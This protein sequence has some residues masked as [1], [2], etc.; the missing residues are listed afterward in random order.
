MMFKSKRFWFLMGLVTILALV[1]AACAS[2]ATPAPTEAPQPEPTEAP[3]AAETEAPVTEPTAACT[4][5]LW[6]ALPGGAL[7]KAYNGELEGKVVTMMGPFT[8]GDIVRFEQSIKAFEEKTGIDIQYEG[9][10]E[11]EATIGVRVG[12]NDVPDIVD[13]PQPGLLANF[14]RQGKFIDPTTFLPEEYL[15]EQYTQGWLD[16]GTMAGAD[17]QPATGGIWAR[18]NGKSQVWYP[19]DDFEAAGYAI[20]T[21]WDELIALS[22]QIKADG[23]T[24]W[25]VGIESGAAT[26]WP[27]TDWMEEFML[28]TTTPENYDKWVSG[29]LKF[30]SPEVR[31]ALQKLSDLWLTEGYVY[32]GKEAIATTFFGDAPAPMFEQP[33]KCWLHKQ[34]NFITAFFPE[35]VKV[36]EDFDFF[37]L[38]GIDPQFGDPYLVAGDI[39]AMWRDAPEVQAVY[40]YFTRGE[41]LKEWLAAGGALAPQNDTCLEWYTDPVEQKIAGLVK[42]ASTVRFDASDLMPGAVGSGSFWKGMTDYFSGA[43]D[44]DTVLTEIDASW[45]QQ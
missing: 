31:N 37:Y 9:T 43:A 3:P 5:E 44:M 10:K 26:G 21:S 6:T 11:F 15:Q 2:P 8:E 25:C 28:R 23:D 33:P 39:Y 40:E 12:A 35:G 22:D 29:E 45:P 19:K 20:P 42:D 38:P 1:L 7:E 24:P 14:F 34:G 36:G 41:S 27:A 32:G 18:F 30:D 17:G 4:T 16:M 13:F